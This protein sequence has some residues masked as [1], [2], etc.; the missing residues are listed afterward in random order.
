M[1]TAKLEF[2]FDWN[3]RRNYRFQSSCA[4][5]QHLN[6]LPN[7]LGK[8][9]S[10][11]QPLKWSSFEDIS[12]NDDGISATP[13]STEAHSFGRHILH[14]RRFEGED[15]VGRILIC[16]IAVSWEQRHQKGEPWVF[17]KQFG[18]HRIIRRDQV[19]PGFE[20]PTV[21]WQSYY[22]HWRWPL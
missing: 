22:L 20:G 10:L 6:H 18:T 3:K 12:Q 9:P 14:A 2:P 17:A 7:A 15:T 21:E 13:C 1:L 4:T 11:H 8:V 16:S 19:R 5:Q